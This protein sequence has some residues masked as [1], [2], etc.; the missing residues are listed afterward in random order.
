MQQKGN[1]E[2]NETG[3]SRNNALNNIDCQIR[4]ELNDFFQECKKRQ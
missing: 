1:I 2:M 3:K 4:R